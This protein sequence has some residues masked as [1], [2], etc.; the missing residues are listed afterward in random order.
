M[1]AQGAADPKHSRGRADVETQLHPTKATF[2][3]AWLNMH[4][5][6]IL[7]QKSKKGT[8]YLGQRNV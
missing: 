8:W 1:I 4:G 2:I 7:D 5:G 3:F 6:F